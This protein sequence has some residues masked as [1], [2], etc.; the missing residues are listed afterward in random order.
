M[1]I[2]CDKL[3]GETT[4]ATLEGGSAQGGTLLDLLYA[5]SKVMLKLNGKGITS[6]YKAALHNA[7]RKGPVQEECKEK[8]S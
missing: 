2:E 4:Q 1:N 6:W 3:A 5:G 7:R 8:Y